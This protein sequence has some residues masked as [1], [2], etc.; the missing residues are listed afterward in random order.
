MTEYTY[1]Y[2]YTYKV[3]T[4]MFTYR[5]TYTYTYKVSFLSEPS[6]SSRP[7]GAEAYGTYGT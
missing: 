7:A 3:F 4:A 2:T 6:F 1:T 5:Y